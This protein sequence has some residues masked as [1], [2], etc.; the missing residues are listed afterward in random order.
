M[1]DPTPFVPATE[2][3]PQTE[4]YA[5]KDPVVPS[6]EEMAGTIYVQPDPEPEEESFFDF[7]IFGDDEDDDDQDDPM[8]ETVVL[9]SKEYQRS[10][11]VASKSA[12]PIDDAIQIHKTWSGKDIDDDV[13]KAE[14][15]GLIDTAIDIAGTGLSFISDVMETPQDLFGIGNLWQLGTVA[16]VAGLQ[17]EDQAGK[18]LHNL[19]GDFTELLGDANSII[20]DYTSPSMGIKSLLEDSDIGPEKELIV[21]KRNEEFNDAANELGKHI[22]SALA[23]K[24]ILAAAMENPGYLF[25]NRWNLTGEMFLD[26][27]IPPD[28]ARK[29]ANNMNESILINSM[30]PFQQARQALDIAS[31]AS[32]VTSMVLDEDVTPGMALEQKAKSIVPYSPKTLANAAADPVGRMVL[33]LAAE[34]AFDPLWFLGP[35]KAAVTVQKGNQTFSLTGKASQA[36][37]IL[38]GLSGKVGQ[39]NSFRRLVLD[40]IIPDKS[41]K[42]GLENVQEAK[43]VVNKLLQSGS[44][45]AKKDMQ[46]ANKFKS[47]ADTVDTGGSYGLAPFATVGGLNRAKQELINLI[48]AQKAELTAIITSKGPKVRQRT[49]HV[50]KK[51]KELTSDLAIINSKTDPDSVLKMLRS[52]ENKYRYN[53]KVT[54]YK[55]NQVR[56]LVELADNA[57]VSNLALEK[58]L[59]VVGTWHIPLTGKQVEV[60]A[61]L[62]GQLSEVASNLNKALGDSQVLAIATGP[63][64]K[65][66]K[67]LTYSSVQAKRIQNTKNG[68]EPTHGFKFSEK[69]VDATHTLLS[70]VEVSAKEKVYEPYFLRGLDWL[71]MAFGTRR[72]NPFVSHRNNAFET[73]FYGVRQNAFMMDTPLSYSSIMRVK[74]V[75]PE[76]WD[77]YQEALTNYIRQVSIMQSEL[78]NKVGRVYSTAEGALKEYK[79]NSAKRIEQIPDEVS[80]LTN[81]LSQLPKRGGSKET[82][83]KRVAIRKE[84]SQLKSEIDELKLI[85]SD[86]YNVNTLVTDVGSMIEEGVGFLDDNPW[87]GV[88]RTEW[89]AVRNDLAIKLQKPTE[90]IDQA[91]AAMSRFLKGDKVKAD[92]YAKIINQLAQVLDGQTNPVSIQ[93]LEMSD[94]ADALEIRLEQRLKVLSSVKE[95]T[96]SE[97]IY[98]TIDITDGKPFG[99]ETEQ[100][101][102]DMLLKVLGGDEGLVADILSDAAGIYGGAARSPEEALKFFATSLMDDFDLIA[103]SKAAGRVLTTKEL[104]RVGTGPHP[105]TPKSHKGF[106]EETFDMSLEEFAHFIKNEDIEFAATFDGK[107]GQMIAH[108]K[109]DAEGVEFLDGVLDVAEKEV[110]STNLIARGDHVSIH[111]HPSESLATYGDEAPQKIK[112]VIDEAQLQ[113]LNELAGTN[114]APNELISNYVPS[115]ED[116][117]IAIASNSKREV[118]I[119]PDGT[120]WIFDRPA[121]GWMGDELAGDFNLQSRADKAAKETKGFELY[122]DDIRE[123]AN[124]T[125]EKEFQSLKD[126]LV[127]LSSLPEDRR[128]VLV[129]KELQGW[130]DRVFVSVREEVNAQTIELYEEVFGVRPYKVALPKRYSVSRSIRRGD[131]P[132]YVKLERN[133][134]GKRIRRAIQDKKTET[135]ATLKE[136]EQFQV[137]AKTE[138][139]LVTKE[140]KKTLHAK[141]QRVASVFEDFVG[142][143]FDDYPEDVLYEEILPDIRRAISNWVKTDYP[144]GVK[145][146]GVS[147]S[148]SEWLASERAAG[149]LELPSGVT[150]SEIESLRRSQ[151]SLGNQRASLEH[152]VKIL[153]DAVSKVEK[154]IAR[155]GQV[156]TPLTKKAV[157]VDAKILRNKRIKDVLKN[158]VEEAGDKDTAVVALKDSLGSLLALPDTPQ[159][160]KMIDAMAESIARNAFD[161]KKPL[162]L[163]K[164][165][166]Q[167]K[168]AF[169]K[170]GKEE[171]NDL[172][173]KLAEEIP[174]IVIP[175]RGKNGEDFVRPLQDWELEVWAEFKKVTQHLDPEES[176]LAAYSALADSPKLIN[177]KT[178][179]KAQYERLKDNYKQLIGQRM[180]KLP[181]EL[182]EVKKAF[183]GLIKHYEDLYVQYGMDFIKSP[184][185]MLRFW[186]VVDYIPH[187]PMKSKDLLEVGYSSAIKSQER[188]S[189]FASGLEQQLGG[190]MDARKQRA[191]SGTMREINASTSGQSLA[192]DPTTL[193]AR[194]WQSVKALTS[195]ELVYS[196]LNGGVIQTVTSKPAYRHG[197]ELFVDKYKI[198]IDVTKASDEVLDSLVRAKASPSDLLILDKSKTSKEIVPTYLV[199]ADMNLVPMFDR[200]VK[201][202]S[203][204][205]MI[206][207][208]AAKWAEQIDPFTRNKLLVR[209]QMPDLITDMVKRTAEQ[210]EDV[211]AKYVRDIP[212]IKEAQKIVT[213]LLRLKAKQYENSQTLFDPLFLYEKELEKLRSSYVSTLKKQGKSADQIKDLSVK[214]LKG[215]QA[216]AWNNVAKQMNKEATNLKIGD[217]QKVKGESLQSFYAQGAEAWNLYIPRAVKQSLEDTIIFEKR[218][219]DGGALDAGKKFLDAT[220]RFMKIRFTVVAL[221]FHARNAVSNVFSQLL[222]TNLS[223]LSAGVQFD[224]SR[225]N[226]LSGIYDTYGSIENARRVYNLPK[227]STESAFAY[228]KRR[229]KLKILDEVDELTT[230]YDLGDGV[231]RSADE[232]LKILKERGVI[233]SKGTQYVDLMN[234]AEDAT[235]LYSAAAQ[236]QNKPLL[237]KKIM[238]NPIASKLFNRK[239]IS[240]AEDF[241]IVGLP[242]LIA[243][244]FIFPISVPKSWGKSLG[245]MV[246]NQSR[247]S[248]FIANTKRTGS[249]SQAADHVDKFLFNYSDLT[250]SQKRWWRTFVPFFTWTKKNIDLQLTMMKEKPI[251]YSLFNKFLVEQA[252]EIVERYNADVAG[253][254]YV[255][256]NKN[257]RS[258]LAL[259][260][261]HT[262][263]MIRIPVPGRPGFY[264]EGLGLP[265]EAFFD[266]ISMAADAVNPKSRGR[267]DDRKPNLRILG[268]THFL[269]KGFAEFQSEH[270]IY[271]D[272]SFADNTSGRKAAQ[273]IEGLRYV[274]PDVAQFISEGMGFT[275]EQPFRSKT[276]EFIGDPRVTGRA[277]FLLANQPYSRVINDA[278]AISMMHN[279]SFMDRMSPEL[280]EKYADKEITPLSDT[281]KMWDAYT[282]IRIV[283]EDM[284]ARKARSEYDRKK[285]LQEVYR[286][287]GITNIYEKPY[288]RD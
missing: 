73:S 230:T 137:G 104:S 113:E 243:G 189:K 200:A 262:R 155:G 140:L 176:M 250:Q 132:G 13:D 205:I 37:G 197:L 181:K 213:S 31:T 238:D 286:R 22:Y 260:D 131:E 11:K 87:L 158:L 90:E 163:K 263:N 21:Q 48:K 170:V 14:S 183:Q 259:R 32:A 222:D 198:N 276:G 7:N 273:V 265:Q 53:A 138:L 192:I 28:L 103:E 91:I 148:A 241:V 29:L 17:T 105:L 208:N 165:I 270:N 106:G 251:F 96:L 109:G 81:D 287:R 78:T 166:E 246:E 55:I 150:D 71:G 248:S 83:A 2:S 142:K 186:G 253:I 272:Q 111:N 44:Q 284:E 169:R 127:R 242:H 30:L 247:I 26:F 88:V 229:A 282:G 136:I 3:A 67:P 159:F 177:E 278:S 285:R 233:A 41:T 108:S 182:E 49:L 151:I 51:I 268:Q 245:S 50:Q 60:G 4:A 187:L 63:I 206:T 10:L 65:A 191:I 212:Q 45:S 112:K 23:D 258:M 178:V 171:L 227:M 218:L 27:M 5:K 128:S 141:E 173:K 201:G 277:N 101:I 56:T 240:A 72:W 15:E 1:A 156:V 122:I 211:F 216:N 24:K 252:P 47:L 80:K 20:A 161:R 39:A 33:G 124:V 279:A 160:N 125:V 129:K 219:K 46:T 139:T 215:Q 68:F 228:K 207:G 8:G 232:S 35:A 114:L 57:K 95:K 99:R 34:V 86:E 119:N 224:A 269:L 133:I 221:A 157:K 184:E 130:M 75:R 143:H 107:S 25:S 266:Q 255:P 220:N 92:E 264:I 94:L 135:K 188:M 231:L 168:E 204:D 43:Q 58:G 288:L 179:G 209:N 62:R 98:K 70:K 210:R 64:S 120:A 115:P 196:L 102:Q 267:F 234:F 145:I 12:F 59:P 174:R 223:T 100:A 147:R 193:M 16:D 256:T 89:L 271:Y 149:L 162:S 281:W 117:V 146:E 66:L 217:Y 123:A 214:N 254:P 93:K 116:L 167:G 6:L 175:K 274:S 203:N 110:L 9:P 84:I 74:R 42:E 226:S 202:L 199:A 79:S 19:T 235:E 52:V 38:E 154:K 54:N 225:L 121:N 164:S 194:Y 249:F 82:Q 190:K 77:N 40:L 118:I 153:T 76:L 275:S 134:I 195:Q 18:L 126:E 97:I 244:G 152:R 85:V 236:L 172:Q 239:A 185:E 283:L 237:P 280:R 61:K 144:D 261:S 36:A 180:G 69:F 257:S